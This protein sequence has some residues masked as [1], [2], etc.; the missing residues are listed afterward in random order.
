VLLVDSSVWIDFLR[1][2][3]TPARDGLR[4]FLDERGTEIATTEPVI[5]EL[6]AGAPNDHALARLE[7]L[8][9]GFPLLAVDA[10]LDYRNG[11]A[12]YRTA[13]RSGKTVRRLIDCLIAAVALRAEAT[14][15]HKDADYDALAEVAP[16]DVVSFR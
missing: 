8:T 6:L 7:A 4:S 5:L 10:R 1:G 16:L 9:N 3:P 14:L 2:S 15:V 11:A 12:L 13:R